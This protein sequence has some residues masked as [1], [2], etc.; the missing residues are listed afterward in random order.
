MP[1]NEELFMYW[2]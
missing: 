2:Q 1:S